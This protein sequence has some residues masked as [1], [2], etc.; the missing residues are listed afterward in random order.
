MD[1]TRRDETGWGGR[2]NGRKFKELAGNS[3]LR[4]GIT[5]GEAGPGCAKVTPK[6]DVLE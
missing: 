3:I 1:S 5:L 2:T 4:G 6:R